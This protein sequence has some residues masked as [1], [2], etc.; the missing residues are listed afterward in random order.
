MS[1]WYYQVSGEVVGPVS[2]DELRQRFEAGGIGLRTYVREGSDGRWI[3]AARL[4]RLLDEGLQPLSGSAVAL[5]DED[6]PLASDDS[7]DDS[8]VVRR[9][10]L[11]LRPCSDCGAMVSQRALACPRCGRSFH[12]AYHKIPYRGEHPIPILVIF[13]LLAVAFVLSSPVIVHRVALKIG[14]S[15]LADPVAVS[16]IAILVSAMYALSMVVCGA[17]GGA[18]G[19]SRMAYYTGI[20]L[21]LFFGP[22]GVFVT[23]AL[24]KR[25]QCPNCCSRLGGLARECPYCHCGLAWEMQPQW[26]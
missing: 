25:A 3:E 20:L 16:Q 21:G 6:S 1:V 4:D 15:M 9:S 24:D 7:D 23:F 8:H 5:A 2:L 18:V 11:T 10:P 22:L 13:T 19:A 12:G 14:A 17:L 26:Y